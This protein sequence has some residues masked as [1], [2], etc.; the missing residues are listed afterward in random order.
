[1]KNPILTTTVIAGTLDISAAFIHSYL[2]NGVMPSKVLQYI[3]SGI[4]GSD[5]Y[6]G[7]IGMVVFGLL[8][9]YFIAFSYTVCFFWL[10]PKWNILK[11]SVVL[12]S[13]FIALVAWIVTT[14]IIVPLSS[15][16]QG[17][18]DISKALVAVAILIVCIGF[19]IAYNA[20]RHF[21]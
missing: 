19:P 1:M 13:I 10:Y 16:K 5:A 14:Q 3:A 9:H 18:F 4:F 2:V 12:N 11:K 17:N 7:G 6:T 15:A 8:A 20:R 21:K